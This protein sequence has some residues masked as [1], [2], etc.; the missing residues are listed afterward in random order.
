[1]IEQVFE[2][3]EGTSRTHHEDESGANGEPCEIGIL[4]LLTELARRKSLFAKVIGA[5]SAI[6]ITLCL[7]LPAH[8]T[9]TTK[10]MPPQQAQSTASMMMNQ[11]MG[12]GSDPLA[13]I[14]GGALTPKSPNDLY[15]GLIS[16]RPV[17]DAIIEQFGLV[18]VY[19]VNDMTAARKA[20]ALNTL[21]SSE[22]SGF[23]AVS[24]TDR[25]KKRAADIAN[26]YPEQLRVLTKS[27]AV[28]E[29]SRRRLFYEDQ[30][31]QAKDSL[32]QAEVGFQQVQQEKGLVQL[33]AQAK[34][35]IESLAQ[36]RARIAAKEVEVEALRS[37]STD[38]NPDLELAQNE[39]S[40]LR[41]QAEQMATRNNTNGFADLG[42]K[43][44]SGA[45]LE[46]LQADH[47]LRYRQALFDVLLKQLDTAKLDEA[48]DSAIIQVVEPAI[49]PERRSAPRRAL[50]LLTW[51]FIG[52][53]ASFAVVLVQFWQRMARR[54]RRLQDRLKNFRAALFQ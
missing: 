53:A 51:V 48:K 8:Y 50:V 33:D 15:L 4:E 39:L 7:V 16:S 45:G 24:V 44:V 14:A 35:I 25:D 2:T 18:Q 9:A 11:I 40:S 13:S 10:I 27:L 5:S 21:V 52:V 54:N 46:Y 49:M 47:E 12:S 34:S 30:L 6:G 37:Y 17:A 32:I 42:L 26:A 20:L 43:Q 23:I 3:D 31:R 28:T 19:R 38:R 29:A 41:S 1:M 36:I 22:K